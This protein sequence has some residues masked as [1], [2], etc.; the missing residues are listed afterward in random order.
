M[1]ALGVFVEF[2]FGIVG[3]YNAELGVGRG[4]V[5]D[6]MAGLYRSLDEGDAI[7][8]ALVLIDHAVAG[9]EEDSLQAMF[10]Q[11]VENLLGVL[12][13]GPVVE[14]E[15]EFWVTAARS[16][17]GRPWPLA[18]IRLQRREPQAQTTTKQQETTIHGTRKV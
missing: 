7:F 14:G 16:A 8:K 2:A 3:A 4:V 12:L 9:P 10:I 5:A 13:V 11:R 6:E 17:P 18:R 15:Q 1:V